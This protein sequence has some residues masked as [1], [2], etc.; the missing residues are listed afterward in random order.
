MRT[1]GTLNI[2]PFSCKLHFIVTDELQKEMN[3]LYKKYKDGEK[4]DIEVEGC[5][6][7]PC[8]YDIY[9]VIDTKYLTHN[10]ISHEIFHVVNNIQ[11]DRDIVDEESGAWLIGY[12]SEFV[13][14]FLKKKKIDVNDG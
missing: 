3:K 8:M 4:F 5:V 12:V 6:F 1:K 2:S 7:S 13:Y 9:M 14:K 10:T 11:K